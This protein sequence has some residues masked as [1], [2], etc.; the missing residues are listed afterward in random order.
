[1]LKQSIIS[2]VVTMLS[3]ETSQTDVQN[4]KVSLEAIFLYS[5]V[6][7]AQQRKN[8]PSINKRQICVELCLI[9]GNLSEYDFY[10]SISFC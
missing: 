4:I 1:M 2:Y 8:S 7:V 3:E 9:K 10:P 6:Y 5:A